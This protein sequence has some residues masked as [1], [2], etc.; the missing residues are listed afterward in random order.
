MIADIA[1]LINDLFTWR[2]TLRGAQRDKRDRLATYLQQIG[3]CLDD[4]LTDL[5]S[6][7]SAVR[8]CGQLRQYVDLI[9]PT[10]DEALGAERTDRLRQSLRAALVV[11]FLNVRTDDQLNQLEEA[12]G[13]FIALADYLRASPK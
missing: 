9:P 3:T 11:R 1:S 12:A 6:G 5:R 8:A 13:A 7:G 10:I 2:E 4:A